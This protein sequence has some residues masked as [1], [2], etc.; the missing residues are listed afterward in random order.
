MRRLISPIRVVVDELD[1]V[2]RVC[3]HA[4][5]RR[6]SIFHALNQKAVSRIYAARV[7]RKY[8]ELNLIVAHLGGGISVGAHRGGRVI[9]VNN[10]LD[11]DGAFSPERSGTLPAGQLVKLCFSG[12]YTEAQI[13]RMLCGS[14]GL[15][16]L[17]GSN[18][19]QNCS[20]ERNRATGP[21]N[22]SSTRWLTTWPRRSELWLPY[23][24]VG[25][26]RF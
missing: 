16:S 19:V 12:Q 14:G 15:V 22:G 17:A 2:A 23:S 20:N 26:M 13:R 4:L 9:D 21:A 1:D 6:V 25:S 10:A 24:A 18:S 7:G 3:G 11:G 5:F 8:D